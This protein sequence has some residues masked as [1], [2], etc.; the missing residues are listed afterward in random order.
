MPCDYQIFIFEKMPDGS[1]IWKTCVSERG[2]LARKIQE[3]ARNSD[4]EFVAIDIEAGEPFAAK[5][6]HSK[7]KAVYLKKSPLRAGPKRAEGA[8][9]AREAG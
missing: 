2:H 3:L 8:R 9:L 5:T 1:L 6:A 4:N 7:P